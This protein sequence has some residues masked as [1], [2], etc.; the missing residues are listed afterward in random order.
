MQ[1]TLSFF[2][3]KNLKG[4]TGTE[5]TAYITNLGIKILKKYSQSQLFFIVPLLIQVSVLKVNQL[6]SVQSLY[7][8]PLAPEWSEL[9]QQTPMASLD[10]IKVLLSHHYLTKK[11]VQ[12]LQGSIMILLYRKKIKKQKIMN[13]QVNSCPHINM[14]EVLILCKRNICVK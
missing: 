5:T 13:L 6:F 7:F 1:L 10:Y 8:Q 12:D 14:W 2:N 11:F 4:W 9:F 3:I